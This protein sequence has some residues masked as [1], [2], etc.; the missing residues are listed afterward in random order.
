MATSVEEFQQ[1]ISAD[2]GETDDLDKLRESALSGV[3]DE[4][5]GAVWKTLLNVES[6]KNS[7]FS[8]R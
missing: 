3:P 1:L 4:V 6:L 2:T 8:W 5:R 7:L